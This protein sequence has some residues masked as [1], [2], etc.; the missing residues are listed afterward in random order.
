M[1]TYT[2]SPATRVWV[3]TVTVTRP[4]TASLFDAANPPLECVFHPG[5][6]GDTAAE[7]T[8]ALVRA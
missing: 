8:F 2:Q 3:P 5:A 4:F 7:A 6:T 1:L